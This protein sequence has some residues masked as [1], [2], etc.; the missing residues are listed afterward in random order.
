MSAVTHSQNQNLHLT[1]YRVFQP[2][3]R[4]IV[5]L[6]DFSVSASQL[7]ICASLVATVRQ[8]EYQLI[9]HPEPVA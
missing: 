8:V 2:L 9:T 7:R 4:Q 3:G 6:W 5:K 1:K